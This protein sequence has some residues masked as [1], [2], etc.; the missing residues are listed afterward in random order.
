MKK[1]VLFVATVVLVSGCGKKSE[2]LLDAYF[3]QKNEVVVLTDKITEIS[4]S[5]KIYE[6]S[7]PATVVGEEAA[8]CLSLRGDF[9]LR[10]QPE[11]D[12]EFQRLMKG[13]EVFA[14]ASSSDGKVLNFSNPM[15]SW[16][17]YGNVLPEDELSAC[18]RVKCGDEIPVGTK[19][20]KI[21]VHSSAPISVWGIYWESSNAWDGIN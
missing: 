7:Q 6:L 21:I 16:S 1:I 11:M 3:G 20:K 13:V 5:E 14:Q 19:I 2:E 12:A 10:H 17:K 15:Q 9:P 4:K 18:M 8:I